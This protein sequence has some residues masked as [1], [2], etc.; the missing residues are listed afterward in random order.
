M[1]ERVEEAKTAIMDL[2]P[3]EDADSIQMG[4]RKLQEAI[5][6][7]KL[8]HRQLAYTIQLAAWNVT[9]TSVMAKEI[10]RRSDDLVIG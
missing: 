2:G 3:M 9:R 8:T 4:I 6:E 5:L 1:H 10:G 7:G